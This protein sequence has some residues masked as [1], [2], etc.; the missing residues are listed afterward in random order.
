VW[1]SDPARGEAVVQELECGT[2]WVNQ[3]LDLLP[4]A[5]FGGMKHSGIGYENGKWGLAEFTALQT[6]N[7]RK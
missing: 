2:G 1:T 5:P 7:R 6:I 4:V 3:H